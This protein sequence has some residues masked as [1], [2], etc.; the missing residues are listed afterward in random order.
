MTQMA[1]IT[2]GKNDLD[3]LAEFTKNTHW[4][5]EN[6]ENLRAKY[7]DRYVAVLDAGKQVLEAEAKPE[8]IDKIVKQ[9]KNPETCAIEFVTRERFLL[10][11]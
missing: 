1:T 11:V 10:I 9:G 8:L 2:I 7:P 5:L 6:I 3:R 4:L